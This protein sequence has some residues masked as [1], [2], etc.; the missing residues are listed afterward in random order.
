MRVET[1]S[2]ASRA[3][4]RAVPCGTGGPC[5]HV[6]S[7]E[8]PSAVSLPSYLA[9]MPAAVSVTSRPCR[10]VE[11]NG[12]RLPGSV[13][14]GLSTINERLGGLE[15]YDRWSVMLPRHPNLPGGGT[16]ATYLAITPAANA[17]GSHQLQT[18]ETS[19]GVPARTHYWHGVDVTTYSNPRRV[20][21]CRHR[22][23]V[24]A[25]GVFAPHAFVRVQVQLHRQQSLEKRSVS[26]QRDSQLFSGNVITLRPL[27]FQP[28]AFTRKHLCQPVHHLGHQRIGLFDGGTWL[29]DEAGLDRLPLRAISDELLVR[30]QLHLTRV[31]GRCHT[32][33]HTARN[34]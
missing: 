1:P 28:R 12:R 7:I 32:R 34:V 19:L 26:C 17:R 3:A 18:M 22:R 29:I 13:L 10:T 21:A 25:L 9:Q 6:P 31:V 27:S 2:W 15:D 8:L 4:A 24:R 20:V 30:K 5:V 16:T 23:R 11:S 33:C 14:S